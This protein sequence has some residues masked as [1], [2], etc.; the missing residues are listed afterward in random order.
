MKPATKA[1][2]ISSIRNFQQ[3]L[4]KYIN[5]P[6]DKKA[7]VFTVRELKDIIFHLKTISTIT[8]ESKI[9][10]KAAKLEKLFWKV[11]IFELN[12][13]TTV[14]KNQGRLDDGRTSPK[15]KQPKV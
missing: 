10:Q 2:Q 13:R 11:L 14:S 4:R 5:T 9:A 7:R 8:D 1:A 12:G 15:E 3:K 6:S